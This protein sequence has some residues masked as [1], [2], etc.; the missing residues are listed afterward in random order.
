MASPSLAPVEERDP[1]IDLKASYPGDRIFL[2]PLSPDEAGPLLAYKVENL[3]F[4]RPFWPAV[5]P[6]DITPEGHKALVGRLVEK[7]EEDRAYFFLIYLTQT[8]SLIGRVNLNGVARGVSQNAF[9]GYD[10]ACDLNGRGLM[11][12]A[13]QVALGV[14]F[15]DVGLHRVEAAVMPRNLP[16][17]R[18]LEKNRFRHEGYALRYLQING[19]WED[20]LLFAKTSDDED[21]PASR[22]PSSR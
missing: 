21:P 16:S 13:V 7:M 18:V 9:L 8:G 12:E 11:T 19:K 6:A 10:M 4:F 14:A 17:I 15:G 1:L 20:H 3:E 22:L 2:R 5:N